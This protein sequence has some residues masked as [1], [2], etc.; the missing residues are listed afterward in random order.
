M[1]AHPQTVERDSQLGGQ[2]FPVVYLASSIVLIVFKNDA[3]ACGIESV[4]ALV[5]A[6][7]ISLVEIGRIR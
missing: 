3:A 2:L 4:E 5:Q 1:D 6:V 7:V